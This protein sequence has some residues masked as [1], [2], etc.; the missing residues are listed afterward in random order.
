M[1][2]ISQ[3]ALTDV[4]ASTGQDSAQVE[5][6][7]STACSGSQATCFIMVVLQRQHTH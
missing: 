2:L 5:Q 7:A 3:H 4:V 1:Q 6:V